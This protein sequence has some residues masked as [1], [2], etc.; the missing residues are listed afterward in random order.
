MM[1]RISIVAVRITLKFDN[2]KTSGLIS[3]QNAAGKCDAILCTYKQRL[4][5]LPWTLPYVIPQ[6]LSFSVSCSL[7][8]NNILQ[9]SI[10]T[11]KQIYIQA[12]AFK[13]DLEKCTS[14]I[15][16]LN[17]WRRSFCAPSLN[18]RNNLFLL[19]YSNVAVVPQQS[20]VLSQKSANGGMTSH[21]TLRLFGHTSTSWTHKTPVS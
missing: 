9:R 5:I 14:T 4:N 6:Q 2:N 18:A 3:G 19:L 21:S 17:Y 12:A 10:K 15:F 16:Q 8:R 7:F 13:F 11:L 1:L 20:P